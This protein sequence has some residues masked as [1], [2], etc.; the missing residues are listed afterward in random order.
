[1]S[2]LINISPEQS[3]PENEKTSWGELQDEFKNK[4]W[5]EQLKEAQET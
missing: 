1:M 5:E 3:I 2:E 4:D